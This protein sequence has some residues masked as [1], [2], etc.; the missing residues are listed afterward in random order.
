MKNTL[1]GALSM[2]AIFMLMSTNSGTTQAPPRSQFD[3]LNSATSNIKAQA[4]NYNINNNAGGQSLTSGTVY[5]TALYLAAP[6]TI[7]G[8][9]VP[10][11]TQ[12]VYTP[13]NNNRVGLYSTN[14]TTLTLVASNADTPTMYSSTIGGAMLTQAFSSTYSA[15][16]GL[17]YI[18]YLWCSSATTTSPRISVMN[19]NGSFVDAGV[20]GSNYRFGSLA[21]QT[22]LPS[23]QALS[24]LNHSGGSGQGIIWAG[25]Y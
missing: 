13:T 20:I 3:L 21:S 17:Y 25:I 16:A 14:G 24:G 19:L 18:A 15:P 23:T 10:F 8:A 2:M 9:Y 12:G 7:T 22:N 11:N 1:L 4:W 6:S 5:F